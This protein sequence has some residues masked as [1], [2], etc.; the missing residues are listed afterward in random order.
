MNR[1]NDH[2]LCNTRS[3]GS[4]TDRRALMPGIVLHSDSRLNSRRDHRV[5]CPLRAGVLVTFLKLYEITTAAERW[6]IS[7]LSKV[8]EPRGGKIPSKMIRK[9]RNTREDPDRFNFGIVLHFGGLMWFFIRGFLRFWGIGLMTALLLTALFEG[10]RYFNQRA[11]SNR[12]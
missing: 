9:N 5:F 7:S 10:L 1:K 3:H 11:N 4:G 2:A 8:A 12:Q 6:F